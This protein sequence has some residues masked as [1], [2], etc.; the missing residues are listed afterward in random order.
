M[1]QH[2]SAVIRC[3]RPLRGQGGF[4]TGGYE[5]YRANLEGKKRLTNGG[6]EFWMARDLQSLLAY[7]KWENFD[8]AVQ[9]ARA[10]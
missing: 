4:M 2:V 9:R 8:A 10:A 3:P 1:V 6:K 7:D 5:A